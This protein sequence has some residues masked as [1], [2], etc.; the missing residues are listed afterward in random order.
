MQVV[1]QVTLVASKNPSAQLQ[2][3]GVFLGGMVA[4]FL[5]LFTSG[6]LF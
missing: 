3:L 5:F 6:V 2:S 4:F 1:P